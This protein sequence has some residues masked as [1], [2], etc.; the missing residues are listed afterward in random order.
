LYSSLV[1][2]SPAFTD[3][4]T[5]ELVFENKS[6]LKAFQDEKI[7]INAFL[8]KKFDNPAIQFDCKVQAPSASEKKSY[9]VSPKD[10][11]AV[12]SEKNPDLV[13]LQQRLGLRISE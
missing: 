6:V 8:E 13:E 10:Q 9:V 1:N 7:N 11:F 12:M 4:E 5:V 3:D 2:K